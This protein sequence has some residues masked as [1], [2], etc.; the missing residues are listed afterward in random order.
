MLRDTKMVWW[1]CNLNL[2]FLTSGLLLVPLIVLLSVFCD[3]EVDFRCF[4]DLCQA[5]EENARNGLR[6]ACLALLQPPPRETVH[7]VPPWPSQSQVGWRQGRRVGSA[8]ASSL[9]QLSLSAA[10]WLAEPE[11][12]RQPQL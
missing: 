3:N 2:G 6:E 11:E 12:H 9:L 4:A 8:S 10:P 1:S 5:P 7:P